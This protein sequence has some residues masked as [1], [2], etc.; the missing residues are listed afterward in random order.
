MFKDY[1]K[2]KI[3]KAL[4]VSLKKTDSAKGITGYVYSKQV[5]ISYLALSYHLE[6]KNLSFNGDNIDWKHRLI[7][8][9]C[10][11]KKPAAKWYL[12]DDAAP[13]RMSC[14]LLWHLWPPEHE[15]STGELGKVP[16]I[17]SEKS[18]AIL[19]TLNF[20][21][22]NWNGNIIIWVKFSPLSAQEVSFY[23]VGLVDVF[24]LLQIWKFNV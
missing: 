10:E 8:G 21:Y 16:S 6:H 15:S 5:L 13:I 19:D 18:L 24:C 17:W 14:Y 4:Y 22:C 2:K 1:L 23:H 9:P 11:W 20:S 3:L 12:M 7:S